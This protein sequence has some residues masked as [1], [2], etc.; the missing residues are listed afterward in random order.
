MQCGSRLLPV[1]L[2]GAQLPVF[3]KV[4]RLGVFT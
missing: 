2:E 1:R 3:T 4:G